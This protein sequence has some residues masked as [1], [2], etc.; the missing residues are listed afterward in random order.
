MDASSP[1]VLDWRNGVGLALSVL[2]AFI[3]GPGGQGGG[4]FYIPLFSVLLG[5]T[6]N[7]AAALSSATVFFG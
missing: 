7:Q 5:F 6:T 1:F 3:S 4:S 2:V